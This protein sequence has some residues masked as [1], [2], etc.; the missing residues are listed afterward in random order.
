MAKKLSIPGSLQCEYCQHLPRVDEHGG[1]IEGVVQM[2]KARAKWLEA[3]A[4]AYMEAQ[5]DDAWLDWVAEHKK[6]LKKGE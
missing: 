6:L 3:A 5:G 4:N 2:S 1:E